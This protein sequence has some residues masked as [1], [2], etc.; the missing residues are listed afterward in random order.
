MLIILGTKIHDICQFFHLISSH[1]ILFCHNVAYC[2]VSS[3]NLSS[4]PDLKIT[5]YIIG[6]L[7]HYILTC[8]SKSC[9][10][11]IDHL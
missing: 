9:H 8:K 5:M 7:S 4:V 10:P 2:T 3:E 1:L 6:V 11:D